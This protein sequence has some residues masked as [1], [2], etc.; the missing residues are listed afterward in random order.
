[1][2]HQ[3]GVGHIASMSIV[4]V[5][6]EATAKKST[7]STQTTEQKQRDRRKAKWKVEQLEMSFYF[8]PLQQHNFSDIILNLISKNDRYRK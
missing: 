1:M 3:K 2:D 7:A 5:N 4:I 8:Q 6:S